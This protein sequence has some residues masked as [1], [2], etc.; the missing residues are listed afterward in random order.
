VENDPT[1]HRVGQA[2]QVSPFADPVPRTWAR[3]LRR[4]VLDLATSEH[5]R[6]FPAGLHVGT[7]GGDV[8]SIVDDPD[9]DR[10]VRADVLGAMLRRTTATDPLVWITRA[11]HLTWHDVDASWLAPAVAVAPERGDD[12]RL[13]VVTRH[14]W[15]DPRSGT[16]R[17]WKRIRQR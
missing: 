9:W 5:R 2:G 6:H 14:G 11:G 1:T 8:L 4:A 17:T 15:L 13:V 12:A 10:Q 7:P 16:T 3:L